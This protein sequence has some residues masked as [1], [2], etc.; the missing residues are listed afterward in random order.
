MVVA[1][2]VEAEHCRKMAACAREPEIADRWLRL[3]AEYDEL[4]DA[5]E[6]VTRNPSNRRGP[7]VAA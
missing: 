7:R 5:E 2:R 3:A 6:R 1:Y 4:A